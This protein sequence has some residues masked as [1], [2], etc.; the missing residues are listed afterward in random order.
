M[1][2]SNDIKVRETE[3]ILMYTTSWCADCTRV[4]K[5][6]ANH[7]LTFDEIDIE[8]SPE[9]AARVEEINGGNRSVPTI[10]VEFSDDTQETLVE[11]TWE[12]LQDVFLE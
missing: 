1:I 7:A 9:A 5:F 8:Q 11:P 2:D 12:E 3:S 6:F 4:K 10:I